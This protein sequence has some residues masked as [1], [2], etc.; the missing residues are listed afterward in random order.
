MTGGTDSRTPVRIP[1]TFEVPLSPSDGAPAHRLLVAPPTH[2]PPPRGGFPVLYL[3]DGA[4]SFGMLV[5][6]LRQRQVRPAMTGIEAAIVVG[7]AHPE[8]PFPYDRERRRLEYDTREGG[9]ADSFLH[10]LLAD[11]HRWVE[12]RF[13][14]DPA[15]RALLGHSLAGA[16]VLH[17]LTREPRSHA[18]FVAASPSTWVDPEGFRA[19]VDRALLPGPGTRCMVLVGEFDQAVAPWQEGVPDR[20]ALERRRAERAMVDGARDAALRLTRLL[21]HPGQVVFDVLPGEDHASVLPIAWNRAL[22]FV[23]GTAGGSP[24][25][26]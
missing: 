25:G 23:L 24:P 7:I 20:G 21:P 2:L 1:G 15:R 6:M 16:F 14:V 18:R 9:R 8:G 10:F 3:L 5:E 12:S 13:P 22:R 19:A 17:A 11:V 26:A 4:Q